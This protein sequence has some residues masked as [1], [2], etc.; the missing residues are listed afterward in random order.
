MALL[1][2]CEKPSDRA[3]LRQ[4]LNVG[5]GYCL[6][7]ARSPVTIPAEGC[8]VSPNKSYLMIATEAGELEVAPVTASGPGRPI[9]TT[10]LRGKPG[11]T[12][13]VLQGDGNLVIYDVT[14][15]ALWNSVSF[16]PAGQYALSVRDDGVAVIRDQDQKVVWT[17]GF[18]RKA[19][20]PD[21]KAGA[22][23]S[24]GDC[25]I[26]PNG[27][28]ALIMSAQGSLELDPVKDG[29]AVGAPLWT[30]KSRASAAGSASAVMQ[31][32]G[33][34]VIYDRAEPDHNK[35]VWNSATNRGPGDYSVQVT[36]QGEI[37]I[38]DANRT[39][40]SSKGPGQGKT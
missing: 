31:G 26:S 14:G 25:V 29:D 13:A 23:L 21:W 36:D 4:A 2:A 5:A 6:R 17:S 24:A 15:K 37:R 9:W 18:H 40:W 32:D 39:I 22:W 27:G 11:Q 28:Y 34:L 20:L 8:V 7:T 30:S 35:A 3:E 19:C 16:G 33:N 38:L 12:A 10:G 1:A